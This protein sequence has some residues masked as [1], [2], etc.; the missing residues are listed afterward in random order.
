MCQRP[1]QGK[2][3]GAAVILVTALLISGAPAALAELWPSASPLNGSPRAAQAD[4]PS[5]ATSPDA[6]NTMLFIDA[7]PGLAPLPALADASPTEAETAPEPIAPAMPRAPAVPGVSSVIFAQVNSPLV[8]GNTNVPGLSVQLT[9]EDSAQ[10]LK[11][12]PSGAVKP[13]NTC[14]T[15]ANCVNVDPKTL[16]FETTFVDPLNPGRYVSM[17]PGDRVRVITTGDDPGT[18]GPDQPE[19]KVVTIVGI[20]ACGSQEQDRV[21]G[22]TQPGARVIITSDPSGAL[23]APGGY[24]TPGSGMTFAE[25]IAGA[26]GRF[27]TTTFRTSESATYKRIDLVQGSKGY[28]RVRVLGTS[29][30]PTGDEVWTVWG[31]NVYALQN[32]PVAHGYAY[33]M[34]AA[35]S[36][37]ATGVV[38]PRPDA[39]V[40][41][42]LKDGRGVVK[43]SVEGDAPS[44]Q[45]YEAYF[46]EQTITG[47]DSVDVVIAYGD[48]VAFA[49]T[50]AIL[51][52]AAAADLDANQVVGSGP[53]DTLMVIGAGN[54]QGYIT[55]SSTYD[56]FEAR[57]ASNGSGDFVSG[58]VRCGTGGI[59]SLKP[60]SFGYAGYETPCGNFVY[61][62][63]A[64][65]ST[66]V[67]SGFPY[68]D[69]WIARGT[70]WPSIAVFGPQ[71]ETKQ[72][73]EPVAPRLLWLVK[74]KLFVNTYFNTATSVYIEPGDTV[75]VASGRGVSAILVDDLEARLYAEKD[76]VAGKAPPGASLRVVPEKD[77]ASWKQAT[78]GTGGGYAAANP[79][80][81]RSAT[82]CAVTT[83]TQNLAFGDYGRVYLSHAD[84]NEVFTTFFNRRM[85]VF[86]N[87]NVVTVA[88][89]PMRAIDW[90]DLLPTAKRVVTAQYTPRDGA[91]GE[92]SGVG[93]L[94][95]TIE[96]RSGD[97]AL[98]LDDD[99]TTNALIRAG[100]ELVARFDEGPLG[101]T[102]PVTLTLS[103]LPLVIGSPD[104]DT[105]T[106][107]AVGPVRWGGPDSVAL[108][109]YGI[110]DWTGKAELQ[111]PDLTTPFPYTGSVAYPPVQFKQRNA[112]VPLASGS[113]GAVS[114][115]DPLGNEVY[116]SWGVTDFPYLVRIAPLR[117]GDTRVCGAVKPPAG[118]PAA[119]RVNI[120]D[121]TNNEDTLLA[122]GAS[123]GDG[124]FCILVDPPLYMGQVLLGEVNGLRGQPV[125]VGPPVVGWLPLLSGN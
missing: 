112:V 33:R 1:T 108:A 115:V 94:P 77:R 11:G 84:G 58:Q 60:G 96:G 6:P 22:T 50:V 89:F 65:P 79:Y 37:L 111:S 31:Q 7:Q 43:T 95:T 90:P 55:K 71:G 14:Q 40:T 92:G 76:I 23:T 78:A 19:D 18:P 54:V 69:G 10:N 98:K 109:P 120:H 8:W 35:P 103:D 3:W 110:V 44:S 83:K 39:F 4:R 47:G 63:F 72:P 61:T 27:E 66:A 13:L 119:V 88:G 97:I 16:Y 86:E 53:P 34:I 51:P 67:M 48:E 62:A 91:A 59:V 99:P 28:A 56:A 113:T 102:R 101:L 12:I 125:V 36:G 105:H 29:G 26:D 42:T 121:V 32:S 70:D 114:F 75:T 20:E 24:L 17:R 38:A 106:V 25:V 122:S 30:Q 64:S 85:T 41:L 100:G 81:T 124:A 82:T 118:F 57:V 15:A 104:T 93:D 49:Q 107:A 73:P 2:R 5:Q 9:L 116:T 21:T 52:V 68:L 74:D 80:A 87:A 45:P 117:E 46:G 123:D